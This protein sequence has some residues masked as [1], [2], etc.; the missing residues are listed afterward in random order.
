MI[1]A[2]GPCILV[3][4]I[5]VCVGT[6]MGLVYA[7]LLSAGIASYSEASELP[8]LDGGGLRTAFYIA[9]GVCTGV[10]L[11]FLVIVNQVDPGVIKPLP[12]K[13][14]AGI[15][16]LADEKLVRIEAGEMPEGTYIDHYGQLCQKR[17]AADGHGIIEERY[18]L[19][20]NIWRPPRASHCRKCGHCMEKFDHHCGIVG[21]CIARKNQRFFVVL[22]TLGTIGAALLLAACI[23]WLVQ[24]AWHGTH[25]WKY[26][27]TY[28]V[29][30]LGC[31]YLYTC[32][33]A[34]FTLLHCALLFCDYI[35]LD[36][37]SYEHPVVG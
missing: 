14:I 30:L 5:F 4:I 31:L 29:L 20:C 3:T 7:S 22:L 1:V 12:Y 28:V 8:A 15:E 23:I 24:Q 18:C 32:F 33:A 13:V 21:T 34:V 36:S 6:G 16:L 37:K 19:T 9:L 35:R 26:W 27:R 25:P 2:I 11:I 10:C 17:P